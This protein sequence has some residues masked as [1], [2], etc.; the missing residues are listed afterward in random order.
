MVEEIA[1]RSAGRELM[2]EDPKPRGGK[3]VGA[4]RPPLTQERCG[5]GKHTQARAM[6]LRLKCRV[7]GP[8]GAM[9]AGPQIPEFHAQAPPVRTPGR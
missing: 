3:R 7:K 8:T 2:S 9:P 1:P 6:R 4:G 5:C